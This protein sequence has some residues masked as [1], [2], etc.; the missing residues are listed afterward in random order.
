MEE[1]EIKNDE[2]LV[3]AVNIVL[4]DLSFNILRVHED[5]H[6]VHDSFTA[7]EMKVFVSL[8]EAVMKAAAHGHTF[9]SALQFNE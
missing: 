5:E 6:S 1:L 9:C 7:N 8:R 3:R 4:T 2:L